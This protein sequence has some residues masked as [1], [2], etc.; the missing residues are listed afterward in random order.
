MRLVTDANAANRTLRL[1]Y[2]DDQDRV[3]DVAGNPVTY[4]ASSTEDYSFSAYQPRGEWEVAATNLVPL[5]PALLPPSHDF[6]VFV[7]SIQAGD[8]L[9]RIALVVERFYPPGQAPGIPT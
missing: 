4:P 3:Y 6:R 5:H 7:D 1:E 8:Q 2:R 9:S